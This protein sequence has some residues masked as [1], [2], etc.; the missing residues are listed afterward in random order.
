ML[1]LIELIQ[2]L[3]IDY[4]LNKNIHFDVWICKTDIHGEIN[5]NAPAFCGHFYWD[6]TTNDPTDIWNF[7]NL[8]VKKYDFEA[9]QNPTEYHLYVILQSN[10]F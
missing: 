3:K 8:P 6:K 2:Q 1:N 7:I 10:D 5:K 4:N 9:L